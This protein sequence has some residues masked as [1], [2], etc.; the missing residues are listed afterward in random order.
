MNLCKFKFF[1]VLTVFLVLSLSLHA[2]ENQWS[3]NGP[4]ACRVMCISIHPE[5][6]NE[7]YLGTVT[8]GLYKSENTGFNWTHLDSDVLPGNMRMIKFHPNEPDTM[9]AATTKGLYKS[10]DS[11]LD[12]ELISLPQGDDYEVRVI[13]VHPTQPNIL[14]ANGILTSGINYRSINGGLT[15]DELNME[16]ASIVDF[17]VDPINPNIIFG[18]GQSAPYRKSVYKS[19]DYGE[20]WENIHNDLDTTTIGRFLAIDPAEP[21]TIYFGGNDFYFAND[22]CLYKSIDGGQHWFDIT[23]EGLEMVEMWDILVLNDSEHTVFICT[24]ADGVLKSTDGGQTWEDANNGL[25]IRS[26]YRIE[27][28]STGGILYLG[29]LYDGIYRSID[30]GDSWQ[31]ISMNINHGYCTDYA[32]NSANCDEQLVGYCGGLCFTDNAGEDWQHIDILCPDYLVYPRCIAID[33]TNPDIFLVGLGRRFLVD[34]P[35]TI[36]RSF[37]R[38]ATWD[39]LWN[40]YDYEAYFKDLKQTLDGQVYYLATLQGAYFSEDTGSSWNMVEGISPAAECRTID[41]SRAD[42]NLGFIGGDALYKTTNG[43]DTWTQID[44]PPGGQYV[45]EIVCD[46]IND[47]I[48]Y[49]SKYYGDVFKSDDYGSTW[50]NIR[51]GL[52][53]NNGYKHFSG[54]AI[55]PYNSD[56]LY[57]NTPYHGVYQSHDRGQ[58]WEPYSEGQNIY[59]S[60]AITYIDPADSNRIFIA[61]DQQSVWSITRTPVGIDDEIVSLPT[62]YNLSA[63]PNPFNATTSISFTLIQPSQVT[64]DIYDI[65]GRRTE[66]LVEEYLPAGNH[67]VLWQAGNYPSGIYFYRLTAGD[68]HDSRK[69][70]LLK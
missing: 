69:I 45:V 36:I 26:T 52:P 21:N 9:Y 42:Y 64:L 66:S 16:L 14:M 13:T 5:N 59:Y 56:N 10:S 12:W 23:P 17:V 4:E 7:V 32:I 54:L 35:H 48:V 38:G 27:Y 15:W 41:F 37:D 62:Q 53:D 70:T 46:P 20:T 47:N 22:K 68:Y 24:A 3:S 67:S 44:S 60:S 51:N 43:G 28:D 19:Y 1:E 58:S 8:Y 55:N 40:N 18:V 65:L 25:T 39:T 49:A 29:T 30:N 57:I 34:N 50:T 33:N 11:G 2:D 31:K 6:N 63:Y 61:T